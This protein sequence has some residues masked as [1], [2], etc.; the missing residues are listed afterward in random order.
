MTKYGKT[1]FSIILIAFI[2]LVI[3]NSIISIEVSEPNLLN[4]FRIED[5][6]TIYLLNYE[7]KLMCESG[8]KY[9]LE[10]EQRYGGGFR[11]SIRILHL[12]TVYYQ[13]GE[14]LSVFK[15]VSGELQSREIFKVDLN[16]SRVMHRKLLYYSN[17]YS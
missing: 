15:Y 2:L 7:F 12:R 6:K 11:V 17:I 1:V 3:L 13:Q 10:P 8:K 9:T 4:A 5:L 14:Q 16:E